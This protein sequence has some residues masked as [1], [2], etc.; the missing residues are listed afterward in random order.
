MAVARQFSAFEVVDLRTLG[1]QPL[2]AL[3]E[4]EEREWRTA[5]H[6][7][8][9]PSV[10]MIRKHIEAHTLPGYAALEQGE[11]AGYCF[12]VYEDDKGLLGDLYV[13]AH[14]RTERP[15]G[16]EAGIA[17]LLAERALETLERAPGLR[18]IE[19]QLIPFGLEPLEP[20]FEARGFERHL[21]LFLHRTLTPAGRRESER[22]LGRAT[23]NGQ[24]V[25][26]QEWNDGYFEPMA[27]LIVE[28]YAGHVDSRINDHYQHNAGALRFLK[29]VVLFPGC[30]VFLPHTSLVAVE[31]AGGRLLGAVL[32]SQVARGVAHITQICVRPEWQGNGLGHRLLTAAM[33]RLAAHGTSRVSLT[34]TA[35]NRPAVNLYNQLGFETLKEFYAFAREH[36]A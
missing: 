34:V 35:G 28:A 6:W 26:L 36:P 25:V 19:A 12:F 11:V 17:T 22:V 21:R 9:R 23:V 24:A 4:E 3:F 13:P 7:D 33:T 14:Y 27:G 20:V 5:L 10:E 2:R 29:N 32:C 1:G 16:G 30:G 8:Y 31:A 18:R 15:Y